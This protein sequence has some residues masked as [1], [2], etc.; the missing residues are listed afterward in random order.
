MKFKRVSSGLILFVIMMVTGCAAPA[1]ETGTV[2]E[3]P[4][5]TQLKSTAT[6]SP[7]NTAVPTLTV[8]PGPAMEVGSTYYYVDGTTLVAVPA[9]EFLMGAQGAD[10]PEHTVTLGD[11]W[12]YATKVTNRQYALCETLG[13]CTAPNS[14]D[15][16]NYQDTA[17]AND[18]VVGVTYDQAVAYC[19]FVQGRLPTE[20]EWEKAARNPDGGLY[21]WGD[22]DPSCDLANFNNCVGSTTS[23]INY[24]E[25]ISYYGV[26]DVVGNTFEWVADWYAQD[27]YTNSP[28][29]NPQG[30]ESGTTRSLRSSSFASDVDQISVPNRTD[31][32]PQ[33]HRADIGF[34]C[35]IEDP[36]YFAPFCESPF[37][38]G[39][40]TN[41][42]QSAE[43]CPALNITQAPYC[44]GKLP[45]T[46]VKFEGPSDATIDASNCTPSDD[47]GLFTCQT[48]ETV[49]SITANCQLNLPGS[50]LC[51]DGFSPQGNQCMA[52]G[53]AGQCLDGNYDSVQGCCQVQNQ[54]DVASPVPVCPVGTFYSR[55]ENACLAY[56]V[57]ELVTVT[58]DV[59]FAA[60]TADTG[61]GGGGG[62]GGGEGGGS[63]TSCAPQDCGPL[64]SWSPTLCCCTAYFDPNTCQ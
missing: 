30:P 46:N 53:S 29:E 58:Q 15:N 14:N 19:S 22:E 45:L 34:R 39:S 1:T 63:P 5:P 24:Q 18:P 47:P 42:A 3:P 11:Y 44:A 33:S 28:A 32:D 31:E 38:Y 56:S 21:P 60:C 17:R 54:T 13:E 43:A 9:G 23:V 6:D 12:I 7:P 51:P 2:T 59:L 4:P 41:A 27:Y 55:N 50:A 10:N 40:E 49:V 52:N 37:V 64:N 61:G 20:A 26:L 8:V 35:V 36:T 48:P 16:P 62:D 25:A 57:Q